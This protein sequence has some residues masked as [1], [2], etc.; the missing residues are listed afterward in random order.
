MCTPFF[1]W[2]FYDRS[3][4]SSN[5]D[6]SQDV[7]YEYGRF[8][9]RSNTVVLGLLNIGMR[10]TVNDRLT[11]ELKSISAMGQLIDTDSVVSTIDFLTT[12][13]SC[14]ITGGKINIDAGIL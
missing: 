2:T 4:Q 13:E 5:R 7:A 3:N 10:S 8:G 6:F 12:N 11:K 9:I 1:L 14:S